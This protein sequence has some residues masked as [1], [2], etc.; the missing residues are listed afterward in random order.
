MTIESKIQ[1]VKA[2]ID[3]DAV[4]RS[5]PELV[6][7]PEEQR[8]IVAYKCMGVSDAVIMQITG[9]QLKTVKA[10]V[11]QWPACRVAKRDEALRRAIVMKNIDDSLI[12]ASLEL[13]RKDV[14]EMTAKDLGQ[15]IKVMLDIKEKV[16][17]SDD[18]DEISESKGLNSVSKIAEGLIS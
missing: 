5:Y 13:Q 16:Q 14:S 9:L 2:E 10:V 12:R 17:F 4:M 18:E 6:D 8:P 7:V 11:A 3:W 15:H 1:V